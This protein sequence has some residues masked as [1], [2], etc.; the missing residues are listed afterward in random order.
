MSAVDST[1]YPVLLNNRSKDSLASVITLLLS[2]GTLICCALPVLLVTL[3]LGTAVAFL[4]STFP[5]LVAFSSFKPWT[6]AISGA[7]LLLTAWLIYRPGRACPADPE[8]ARLCRRADR[9]N[10]GVFW[11]A[12]AIYLVGFFFAYLYLPLHRLLGT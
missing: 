10:R 5:W 8:L 2:G 7:V 9:W 11:V 1:E 12:A 6:F 3:G 4:T